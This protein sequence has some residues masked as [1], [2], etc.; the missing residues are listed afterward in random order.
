[1]L[2]FC[3]ILKFEGTITKSNVTTSFTCIASIIVQRSKYLLLRRIWYI[4]TII[5]LSCTRAHSR[6]TAQGAQDT[7][8][9]ELGRSRQGSS[10]VGSTR[11]FSSCPEDPSN[12]LIPL[13]SARL[14]SHVWSLGRS[15][16]CLLEVCASFYSFWNIRKPVEE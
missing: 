16:V 11:Q 14:Y 9:R 10:P 13:Q 4:D 3:S 15:H 5:F 7:R 8:R 2:G 12:Q 6:T 1:M